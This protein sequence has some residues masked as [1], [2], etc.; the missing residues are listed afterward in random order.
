MK[1]K[2]SLNFYYLEQKVIT[3]LNTKDLFYSIVTLFIF[4]FYDLRKKK[5]ELKSKLKSKLKKR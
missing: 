4:I 3:V 2:Y 5:P 1:S